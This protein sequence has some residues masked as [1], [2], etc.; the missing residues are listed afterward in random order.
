MADKPAR[1]GSVSVRFA[2]PGRPV[3]LSHRRLGDLV[4]FVCAREGFR[5]GQIDLAVVSTREISDLN[6]RYLRRSG[7]T[8]VLSFD[9]S[10][11]ASQGLSAQ[12]IVCDE[13]A[14][15]QGPFHG[16]RPAEELML[17]VVHGLL[18]VMGYDDTAVRAA[19]RMSARQEE[20]LAKFLNKAAG[21]RGRVGKR[22]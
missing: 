3:R 10:D 5:I 22:R 17:Y 12:I 9:L 19:A 8:D 6:R 18:H 21:G 20:L 13:V 2:H 11:A 4:R 16:L 14:A 15:R 7:P 1:R